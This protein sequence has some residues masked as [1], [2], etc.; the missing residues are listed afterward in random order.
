MRQPPPPPPPS[1]SSSPATQGYGSRD[2]VELGLSTSGSGVGY[3]DFLGRQNRLPSSSASTVS[4]S[5]RDG[6]ESGGGSTG[7]GAHGGTTPDLSSTS[8]ETVV[9]GYAQSRWSKRAAIAAARKHKNATARVGATIGGQT[10]IPGRT[11]AGASSGT[12]PVVAPAMRNTQPAIRRTPDTGPLTA[13]SLMGTA[14]SKEEA[15]TTK[16]T[17]PTGG[18]VDNVNSSDPRKPVAANSD[19][20]GGGGGQTFGGD[21]PH[22]ASGDSD[23]GSNNG[24]RDEN[25]EYET[26]N[27]QAEAAGAGPTVRGKTAEDDEDHTHQTRKEDGLWAGGLGLGTSKESARLDSVENQQQKLHQQHEEEASEQQK[28]EQ[29]AEVEGEGLEEEERVDD[30]FP[31]PTSGEEK[32]GQRITTH[33]RAVLM[34]L[35]EVWKGPAWNGNANWG[36]DA[37]LEWWYNVSVDRGRVTELILPRNNISGEIPPELGMLSFLQELRLHRN[38]LRGPIPSAIGGL[39]SLYH[40]DLRGNNLCGPIPQEIGNL[41]LLEKL[42]LGQNR[43]TG[44]IPKGIGRLTRLRL[45]FLNDN[46]LTGPVPSELG[47]LRV[48]TELTIGRNRLTGGIPE[49]L[50]NLDRLIVLDLSSNYLEGDIPLTLGNLT[51]LEYLELDGNADLT[52][53]RILAN[54]VLQLSLADRAVVRTSGGPIG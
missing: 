34:I 9:H 22:S 32:E 48:L 33:D 14:P 18:S 1:S 2:C 5:F 42:F 10:R 23:A 24:V 13:F 52:D 8:G 47:R 36:S 40:L 30:D 38:S 29:D 6:K 7:G 35:F 49:E 27:G 15:A 4:S 53:E 41:S 11:V 43:L 46:H 25:N 28:A 39:S 45:V 3:P 51:S 26:E 12:V 54:A 20:H 31:F 50:G 19:A 16:T 37:P 44:P 17:T 21:I